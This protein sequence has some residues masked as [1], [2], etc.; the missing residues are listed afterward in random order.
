[1]TVT[2]PTDSTVRVAPIVGF[3]SSDFGAD[4]GI[5]PDL[6]VIEGENFGDFVR[7]SYAEGI[8][9][10]LATRATRDSLRVSHG[11]TIFCLPLV[12]E[13]VMKHYSIKN[14]TVTL[15]FLT[16]KALELAV[17]HPVVVSC[18][19]EYEDGM[20]K[21]QKSETYAFLRGSGS[22]YRI[23]KKSP[24]NMTVWGFNDKITSELD[25]L[26]P[27]VGM[28]CNHFVQVFLCGVLAA[29]TDA[30]PGEQLEELRKEYKRGLV[31][32]AVYGH[33]LR[34]DEGS[35]EV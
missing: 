31:Q 9:P 33:I 4:R 24:H 16:V 32:I 1:M 13:A 18:I 30:L 3:R 34:F 19:K 12:V 22:G 14:L 2:N 21:A 15:Q 25:G 29:C 28:F 7:R 20:A 10:Q 5:V 17:N 26:A 35:V 8:R 11:D 6:S 27:Q 23:L